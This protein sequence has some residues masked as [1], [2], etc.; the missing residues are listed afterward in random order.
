MWNQLNNIL[1]C[2]L[3]GTSFKVIIQNENQIELSFTRTWSEGDSKVPLN[4]DKRWI[5]FFFFI[6]CASAL[7]RW[8]KYVNVF[9]QLYVRFIM[10]LGDTGF[11]AYTILERLKGWPDFD[12]QEGR[13]VFKLQ[14][15]K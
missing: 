8:Y 1:L 3:T 2:R 13:M 9:A 10:L 11:Y 15:N 6:L 4:I 14:Q 5:T 12:L 7:L